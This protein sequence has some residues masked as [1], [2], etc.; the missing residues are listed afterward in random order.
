MYQPWDYYRKQRQESLFVGNIALQVVVDDEDV[1]EAK[2]ISNLPFDLFYQWVISF[3][4]KDIIIYNL[5]L[6]YKYYYIFESTCIYV[7]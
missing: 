5:F 7:M 3:V 1:Q 4:T 6:L 2:P